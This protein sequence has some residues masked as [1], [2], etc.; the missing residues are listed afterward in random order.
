MMTAPRLPRGI[1]FVG[2]VRAR[3]G[4]E[5]GFLFD[6]QSGRVY[7]L[8]ATGAF[9]AAR[10]ETDTPV[11]EIIDAVVEAFEVDEPGARRDLGRFAADLAEEGLV[12]LDG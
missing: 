5:R 9:V 8:N 7:S 10:I 3:L 2:S 1:R 6:Q 12:D 4:A 11:K